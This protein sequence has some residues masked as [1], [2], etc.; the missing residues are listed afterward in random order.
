[1]VVF[2][3]RD[4]PSL[5]LGSVM[6]FSD[7]PSSACVVCVRLGRYQ[8]LLYPLLQ[9][10][11]SAF[12]SRLRFANVENLGEFIFVECF[13]FLREFIFGDVI[14]SNCVLCGFIDAFTCL[15]GLLCCS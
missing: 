5:A 9:L 6:L 14:M 13:V 11:F 4:C 3:F 8:F 15:S 7:F 10:L 12:G 1:M 2:R